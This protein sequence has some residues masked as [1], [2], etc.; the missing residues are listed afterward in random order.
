MRQEMKNRQSERGEAGTKLIIVLVILFLVG[1]AGYNFIPFAYESENFK[2]EMQTAVVQGLALPPPGMTPQDFVKNK[3]LKA[4]RENNIPQDAIVQVTVNK[5]VMQA[6]V[7]FTKKIPML[8]FGLYEYTYE[9]NHV[10][11]PAG[12]LLK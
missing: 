11:T 9:F 10:A 6:Q 2:Q 5:G 1:N 12:Y 3:I 8:P 4:A 7:Y